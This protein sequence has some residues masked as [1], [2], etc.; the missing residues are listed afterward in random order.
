W[1]TDLLPLLFFIS[2]MA[3]GCLTISFLTLIVYWLY[4]GEPPMRAISGLGRISAYLLVGYVVIK[5]GGILISGKG[6]LLLARS[7]DTANFWIELLLSAVI[8]IVVLFQRRYRASKT[9]IFW[10]SL[11]AIVGMSLNRVNVAGLATLS[12]TKSFYFP[13]WTEWMMT[14]GILSAAGLFYLFS[15]EYFGLFPGLGRERVKDWITPVEFD[16]TD[17]KKVYFGGQRLGSLQ[18]YS[19]V[20]ILAAAVSF[21]LVS[22]DAV[23]GV[24]PE[25]T[26]TYGPRRVE[27]AKL[28][29]DNPGNG[30]IIADIGSIP[31]QDSEDAVVMLLDSNRDGRYVLF[32]HDQHALRYR[33]KGDCGVCHHMNKPYDRYSGCYECHSDM[34]LAV[35]VFDHDLHMKKTGGNR[36]CADCHTDESLPKIRANTKGCLECHKA[37]VSE[38]ARIKPSSPE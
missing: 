34:Y 30:F 26:T 8:P 32:D 38:T 37:M 18:L 10:V 33:D 24:A 6:G 15:V 9:A 12:L 4:G 1:H 21:G 22:N 36:H 19:L 20:F 2:S 13:T 5:L 11:C 35:D 17:W 3:L 25:T 16:H 7:W 28:A 14:L 29:S 27:V 31:Q 23:F